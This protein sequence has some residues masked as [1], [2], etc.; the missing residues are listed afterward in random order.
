MMGKK[1]LDSKLFYSLCL[2][3]LVPED[4]IVR[5]LE[6]TVDLDF[7][8]DLCKDY[9]SHTGQPSVD[10]IVIFKMM[11]LGYFYGIVSERRL[12]EDCGLN[13]AFRWYIGYDFDEPTPH[14][15]VL[16]K[17]RARFGKKVFEEFFNRILKICVE[18][19]LVKG[20]KLF[21]DGS[22]IR[23]NASIKSLIPRED[24]PII[25]V[26]PQ[27]YVKR[28]FEENP[29]YPPDDVDNDEIKKH[30]ND[31]VGMNG[32]SLYKANNKDTLQHRDPPRVFRASYR[33]KHK[34]NLD[35]M[36]K[37]DPESSY[38]YRPGMGRKFCYKNHL[39]VDSHGRV[40]TAVVVT[41]GAVPED[42]VLE[43]LLDKQPVEVKEVC[44]DSQY[45]SAQNYALCW[46][47][48]IKPSIPKR[49]AP[50]KK[51]LLPVEKFVYDSEKDRYIC[52]NGKEL[53]R[54]TYEKKT[55]R[56][57]YRPRVKDCRICPLKQS[58][59]PTTQIRSL[60]RPVEQVY[61]DKAMKWLQTEKAK[62][63]L[64]VRSL[65]IE[66]I[67]AEAKTLHGLEKIHYRG[68]EKATIQGLMTA[69]VQNIKR[70]VTEIRRN[71]KALKL[72]FRWFFKKSTMG[73]NCIP[74]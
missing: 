73:T 30:N 12:A 32:T 60:V 9:Y 11:L 29:V 20:E 6:K 5:E 4:H 25:S 10:P 27:E 38:V 66:W 57:H 34:S 54:L 35:Y 67:F 41:P 15:S 50:R 55:R 16:S 14:H 69:S 62:S 26:S 7:V 17:A 18:K 59:C 48:G 28:V 23:A 46:R 68:L 71:E 65:Y 56:W 64:K 36:S 58:C 72:F 63:S 21:A 31:S 24:A 45:G 39:T 3:D 2:E 1:K 8:R 53:R 47:R 44:A 49:T 70:L 42:H 61:I 13:L 52:P 19:G 40:I 22:L 37:T 43:E 51:N 33:K 74:A